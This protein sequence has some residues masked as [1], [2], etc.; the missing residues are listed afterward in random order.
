[1]FYVY[2]SDCR[3]CVAMEERLAGFFSQQ[4]TPVSLYAL[5]VPQDSG[6]LEELSKWF[7]RIQLTR[8][9][10]RLSFVERVPYLIRTNSLGE[11]VKAYVGLAEPDVIRE[12][13]APGHQQ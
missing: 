10:P 1:M 4:R 9:D 6:R 7:R 13:I 3:Y 8:G 5:A 11:I 12:F 2:S